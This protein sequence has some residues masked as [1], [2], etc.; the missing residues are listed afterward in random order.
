M[1]QT[2]EIN[3]LAAAL[4]KAQGVMTGAFK[5]SANP[6][7]KSR[8]ADL[9]SVWEACRKPLAD[10]GLAIIQTATA[11]ELSVSVT[12]MLT[13][14]SGQW[15]RETLRLIPKDASPQALGSCISYGR[16]YALAAMVGVYQTDDDAEA[17]M[18][19]SEI[20]GDLGKGIDP[21][22]AR[23]LANDML[24]AMD[25]DIEEHFKALGVYDLHAK[26]RAKH[27][28]YVAA[29]DL[30]KP[31]ER[32]AWKAYIKQAETEGNAPAALR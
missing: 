1:E 16:R 7:F 28:L 17:G 19:R 12:T 13:H 11:D 29:A 9:E 18:G 6:F 32:A 8:Y 22:H 27:D 3:E 10:N 21:E 2:V 20:K 14:T 30:L 31:K 4:S 24:A 23:S 25:A 15:I 5:D 26:V